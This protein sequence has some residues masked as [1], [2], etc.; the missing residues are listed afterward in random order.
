MYHQYNFLQPFPAIFSVSC[1]RLHHPCITLSLA[2]VSFFIA[3]NTH[4][5]PHWQAYQLPEDNEIIGRVGSSIIKP[6]KHS[7]VRINGQSFV[8]LPNPLF[9]LCLRPFL[10]PFKRF[11]S[12]TQYTYHIQDYYTHSKCS[13][14]ICIHHPPSLPS[15][16]TFFL[17][18]PRNHPTRRSRQT[19]SHRFSYYRIRSYFIPSTYTTFCQ[20]F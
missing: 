6:L 4:H 12:S 2:I 18:I 11:L 17:P 16:S 1:N 3:H 15:H 13:V 19:Q 5:T 20:P 8:C 7:D 9:V 14:T 10:S